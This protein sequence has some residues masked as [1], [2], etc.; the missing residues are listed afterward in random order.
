MIKI[1]LKI[2][3]LWIRGLKQLDFIP[4]SSEPMYLFQLSVLFLHS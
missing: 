4:I 1:G 3:W 2:W